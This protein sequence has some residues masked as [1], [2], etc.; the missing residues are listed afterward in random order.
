MKKKSSN[1]FEEGFKRSLYR[2]KM[3]LIH[4]AKKVLRE[5][6]LEDALDDQ[7]NIGNNQVLSDVLGDI[8][9]QA[10]EN[11]QAEDKLQKM[12][13]RQNIRIN[14]IIMAWAKQLHDFVLFIN[15]P[16]S[17]SSMKAVL[18]QAADDSVFQKIKIS[19]SKQITRIAQSVSSLE[20]ALR[21]YVI[22]G[23]D[24]EEA[25]APDEDEPPVPE[26]EPSE[27]EVAQEEPIEQEEI[28]T[29]SRISI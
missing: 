9:Q 2:D 19:Q 27:K 20:Q 11:Q 14:D 22:G 1:L 7:D 13:D 18:D 6:A 4:G 28:P 16:E 25:N 23:I 24:E 26:P 3:Y 8:Q 17:D 5:D 12:M 10:Q 29:A 15:N 21:S